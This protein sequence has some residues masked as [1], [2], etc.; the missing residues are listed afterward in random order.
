MT[1]L[2]AGSGKT[3][4]RTKGRAGGRRSA[5]ETSLKMDAGNWGNDRMG[6][7][8]WM[9]RSGSFKG[10]LICIEAVKEL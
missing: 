9:K 5:G 3:A 10:R 6:G 4:D 1:A 8:Y 2:F 7:F